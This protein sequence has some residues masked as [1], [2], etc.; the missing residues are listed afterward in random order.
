MNKTLITAVASAIAFILLVINTLFKTDLSVDEE[1]ITSLATLI[2]AGIMWAISNYWNQDYTDTAK[3]FT[4]AMRKAKQLAREGD[5]TLEDLVV[6][7]VDEAEKE[8][9]D[10]D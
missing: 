6:A 4:Q 8:E 3:K 1:I 2:A 5:A 10:D 9:E 7:I